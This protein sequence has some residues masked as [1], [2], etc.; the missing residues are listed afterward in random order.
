MIVVNTTADTVVDE[1]EV[2]TYVPLL[3]LLPTQVEVRH[4]VRIL[5][6]SIRR[7]VTHSRIHTSP[8]IVVALNSTLSSVCRYSIV[9]G[10]TI[11]QTKFQIAYEISL[12]HKLLL[13]NTPTKS[14]RWE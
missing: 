4:L 14:Y 12:L 13:I 2:E 11:T 1:A 8:C 10:N 7:Q 6:R 3:G 5:G 9:T